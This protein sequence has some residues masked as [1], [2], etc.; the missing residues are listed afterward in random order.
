MF[1]GLNFSADGQSLRLG[2]ESARYEDGATP[3]DDSTLLTR[4]TN[5]DRGGNVLGQFA[6]ELNTLPEEPAGFGTSGVNEILAICEKRLLVIERATVEN[7]DG[8]FNNVIK[9]YE[10]DVAGATNVSGTDALAGAD[11][12][13][14]TKRLVLDVNAAGVDPVDSI[15]SIS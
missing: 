12:A 13:P 7:S 11:V 6:Y 9:V 14:S 15:E 4:L 10:V 1:E 2:M 3:T 8:V 5:V